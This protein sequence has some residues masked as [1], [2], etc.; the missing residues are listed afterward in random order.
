MCD[1]SNPIP[2][3]WEAQS[4]ESNLYLRGSPMGV[5]VLSSMSGSHTWGSCFG[6]SSPQSLWH[7]GTVGLMPRNSMGLG[8][9]VTLL[10]K[11][12]H[13]LPCA[14]GPRAKQRL[15]RNLGQTCL[16]F[17]EDLLGKRGYGGP[18]WGKD[19]GSKGLRNNHQCK[20]L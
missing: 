12:T 1:I 9:M 17:L 7:L 13:R 15:H 10:L 3:G 20:L 18:L 6:R 8:G 14:V 2:S 4:L 19:F 5:R 11:G 16:Q